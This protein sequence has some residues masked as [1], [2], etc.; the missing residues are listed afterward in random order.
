MSVSEPSASYLASIPRPLC[1]NCATPMSLVRVEPDK[2]D[3]DMR[4]YQC[5]TC[6]RSE[7]A[8]VKYK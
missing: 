8:V 4:T 6:K 5:A 2:A 7:S 1:P 3:H